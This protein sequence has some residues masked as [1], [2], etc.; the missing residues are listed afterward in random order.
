MH[1]WQG[2]LDT[3]DKNNLSYL[4]ISAPTFELREPKYLHLSP[5]KVE[6]TRCLEE[7]KLR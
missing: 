4:L 2:H 7:Q 6:I 3:T 1:V 5:Q